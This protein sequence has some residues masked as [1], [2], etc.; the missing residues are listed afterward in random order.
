MV[1]VGRIK[2]NNSM[3]RGLVDVTGDGEDT[4]AK[5]KYDVGYGLWSL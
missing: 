1:A 4:G 3:T 2:G 5:N